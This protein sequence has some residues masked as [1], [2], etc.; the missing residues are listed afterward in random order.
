MH[1]H[2]GFRATPKELAQLQAH[3]MYVDDWSK[4]IEAEENVVLVSIPSVHDSTLTPPGYAVVHG[5]GGSSGG[6]AE[7]A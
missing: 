5:D 6:V 4:G 2:L 7:A 1:L 3:Y